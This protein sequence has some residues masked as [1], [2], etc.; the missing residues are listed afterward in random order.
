MSQ[1]QSPKSEVIGQKSAVETRPESS[2]LGLSVDPTPEEVAV[3]SR[4]ERFAFYERSRSCYA[5]VATG[6]RRFYGNLILTKGVI[7]PE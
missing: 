5:I 2:D 7:P 6:E 1:V 3:L 4:I